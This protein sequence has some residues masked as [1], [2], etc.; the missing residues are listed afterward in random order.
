MG[1]NELDSKES[2]EIPLELVAVQENMLLLLLL[3]YVIVIVTQLSRINDFLA[4]S[5]KDMRWLQVVAIYNIYYS[6]GKKKSG[7]QFKYNVDL[8]L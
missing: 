6:S 3:L 5:D 7:D 4:G 1:L 2:N 8:N